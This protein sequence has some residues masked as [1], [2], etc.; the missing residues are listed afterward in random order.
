MKILFVTIEAI[1]LDIAKITKDEGHEVKLYI[2]A[3]WDKDVGDGFVDKVDNWEKHVDWADLIV[4]DDVGFGK[5]AEKLRQKGKAVVGGNAYT[6]KLENDREF[7]QQELKAAGVITLPSEKFTDF[8]EAIKYIK[9]NPDRYVLK[10]SGAVQ[11]EKELLFVGQEPDG[12]DVINVLEH[13]KRNNWSKKIRVFLL[14]K[15]ASGVE[16]AVGAFFNGKDFIFP[17]NINFE[18]KRLFP[19]DIGPSTGEMGTTMFWTQWNKI[20]ESTLLKMKSRLAKSGYIGYVDINC[21]ANGK[22]IYPLEFTTRFGI[23]HIQIAAEGVTSPWGQFLYDI[24]MG[25]EV[26]LKVKK[27][28]QIGIVVAMPP[29]PFDDYT[30]F[31]KHSE[32]ASVLFKKPNFDGVHLGEVKLV[33]DSWLVAGGSGYVVIVTGSGSTMEDAIKQAYNRVDNVMV[34]N[35][36]YRTDIGSRWARDSDVLHAWGYLY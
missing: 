35:M 11:N 6:D 27:G 22:A 5:K 2:D 29:F 26:E 17:V 24:A 15:H 3:E 21:I 20:F 8:D 31:R 32:G 13:Y 18:H 4:F 16:V 28:F 14:Q 33:D 25:N 36:Y 23:P 1:V 12:Q 19:G 7:G 10:P 9:E 34:P 30:T